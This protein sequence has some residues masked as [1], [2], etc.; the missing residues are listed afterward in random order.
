MKHT[1]LLLWLL[2][3]M[4]LPAFAQETFRVGDTVRI[5][6]GQGRIETINGNTA[7]VRFGPGKYDWKYYSLKE[8]E[9]L[10]T[11][12]QT[13]A[14]NKQRW[15][16]HTDAARY[17]NTVDIFANLYDPKRY[18]Q[19]A[20]TYTPEM[21]NKGIAELAGLDAL[22]KSKY[23]GITNVPGGERNEAIRED[24]AD[25]CALAAKR[26]EIDKAARIF[27]AKSIDIFYTIER[28]LKQSFASKEGFINGT[29][30]TLIYE[31]ASWKTKA[32]AEARPKFTALGVEMPA[33]YFADLEKQADELQ[34]IID[35]TAPTR[36][37]TQPKYQDAASQSFAKR[38]FAGMYPGIQVLRIGTDYETWKVFKNNF[39]IPT[40]QYKRGWA[41]VRVSKRPYCQAKE[42][43]VK[44]TYIGGGRFSPTKSDFS[45]GP[46]GGVFM[47]CQ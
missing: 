1:L 26:S 21:I 3:V 18:R 7:K 9:E 8:L 45:Q 38:E 43:V 12:P 16:F 19:V 5:S 33:D 32:A 28:D 47:K 31:R 24:Y 25:W 30:Q 4:A 42:W 2:V 6:E 23:V 36:S 20:G 34:K 39:G 27:A 46:V 40:D 13:E 44:Q 14:Q 22:C 41:L 10:K 11:A 29:V 37:F 15:A 35:Q 17:R